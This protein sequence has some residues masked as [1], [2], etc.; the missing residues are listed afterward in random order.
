MQRQGLL[1]QA[2]MLCLCARWSSTRMRSTH[3]RCPWLQHVV[4][5][6]CCA[7]LP[8]VSRLGGGVEGK[9]RGV[10]G[11]GVGHDQGRCRVRHGG[12]FRQTNGSSPLPVHAH[13]CA[14]GDARGDVGRAVLWRGGTRGRVCVSVRVC[15]RTCVHPHIPCARTCA[16]PCTHARMPPRVRAPGDQRPQRTAWCGRS[17]PPPVCPPPAV[18]CGEQRAVG[19]LLA[20]VLPH[21]C[22]K[23]AWRQGLLLAPMQGAAGRQR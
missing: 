11:V 17:P 12:A 2:S 10:R 16:S 7:A 18:Y 23:A 4:F 6:A 1:R 20:A 22:M 13:N 3:L 9:W 14:G 5:G 15:A 21:C 19:T 8:P